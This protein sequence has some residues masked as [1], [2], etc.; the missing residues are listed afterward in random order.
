MARNVVEAIFV[1][2]FCWIESQIYPFEVTSLAGI[3][4]GFQRRLGLY[5]EV[6]RVNTPDVIKLL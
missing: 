2:A 1:K 4:T 6:G 3:V 5:N